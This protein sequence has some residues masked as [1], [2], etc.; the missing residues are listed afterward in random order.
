MWGLDKIATHIWQPITLGLSVEG[1]AAGIPNACTNGTCH[2]GP[3][4]Q[5]N[6]ALQSL[7]D[8]RQSDIRARLAALDARLQA[9]PEGARQLTSYL[10]ADTAYGVVESEGSSGIHNY[11]YDLAV[12]EKAN[13]RLDQITVLYLPVIKAGS[14]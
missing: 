7:I 13:E 10:Q 14:P 6:R 12:L 8:H 9:L 1:P 3:S 2:G 5:T 4:D 11:Q